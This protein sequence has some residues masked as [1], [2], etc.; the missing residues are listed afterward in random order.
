MGHKY[1]PHFQK[2]KSLLD[3]LESFDDIAM[4]FPTSILGSLLSFSAILK[5]LL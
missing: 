5:D 3:Y 4:T 1:K 2:M